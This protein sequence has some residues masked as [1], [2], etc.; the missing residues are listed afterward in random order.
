MFTTTSAAAAAPIAVMTLLIA[1]LC[2]PH[3]S[4]RHPELY[5]RRGW[6]WTNDRP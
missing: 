1:P 3:Q 2:R 4:W 6:L 5:R